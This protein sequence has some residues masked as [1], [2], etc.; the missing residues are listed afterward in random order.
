MGAI[1]CAYAEATRSKS[2]PDRLWSQL[3]ALEYYGAASTILV[4]DD[5]RVGVTRAARYE[6]EL[7][8]L[9]E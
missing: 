4:P 5:S 1:G 8:R 9:Y 7:Q 2:L 6:P 3:R